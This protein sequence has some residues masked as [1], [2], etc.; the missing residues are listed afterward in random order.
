MQ[1]DNPPFISVIIPTYNRLDLLKDLRIPLPYGS[2]EE[3]KLWE[4]LGGLTGYGKP[5]PI[6]YKRSGA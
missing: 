5:M 6:V 4:E 3:R 1:P 2:E